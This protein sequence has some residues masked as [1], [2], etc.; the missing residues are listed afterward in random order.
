MPLSSS[1][2]R[3]ASRLAAQQTLRS[4]RFAR[5]ARAPR[6]VVAE[7]LESR[8]LLA[9][10]I[11]ADGVTQEV[12]VTG[13]ADSDVV[14]VEAIDA[15][16]V[17]VRVVTGADTVE[18]TFAAADVAKI[19]FNADAGDDLLDEYL[20]YGDSIAVNFTMTDSQLIGLGTDSLNA[21][22]HFRLR[23]NDKANRIDASACTKSVTLLGN[24]G[25]DTLIGGLEADVLDGG[26]GTDSI[27]GGR[28]DDTIL[29]GENV[30]Q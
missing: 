28:G 7:M 6:A 8:Q 11:T 24:D 14:T 27:I 21:I 15:A 12:L 17:R 13:T 4:G 2:A 22:D 26:N 5:N 18:Q 16:N 1:W 23:G 20:E 25:N 19:T 29:G 10:S 9:A 30:T 3:V